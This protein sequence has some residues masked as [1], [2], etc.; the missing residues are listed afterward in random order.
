MNVGVQTIRFSR[1]SF[2]YMNINALTQRKAEQTRQ[3]AIP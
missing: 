3:A 2:L 1:D